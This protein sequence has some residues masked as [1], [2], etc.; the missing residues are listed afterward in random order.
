MRMYLEV[1][2]M[3][4]SDGVETT[5]TMRLEV[6]RGGEMRGRNWGRVNLDKFKVGSCPFCSISSRR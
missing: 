2:E 4:G 6:G 1:C 5:K 3:D